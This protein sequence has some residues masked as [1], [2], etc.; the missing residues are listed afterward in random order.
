MVGNAELDPTSR[1]ARRYRAQQFADVLDLGR[2]RASLLAAQKLAVFLHR[3]AAAGGVHDY[4]IE[5]RQLGEG[6]DRGGCA[7]YGLSLCPAVKLECAAALRRRRGEYLKPLG[8]QYT[9]RGRMH[10][11]IENSL[12]APQ[13]QAHAATRLTPSCGVRGYPDATAARRGPWGQLDHRPQPLRQ[14]GGRQ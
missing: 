4:M 3:G 5:S 11:W 10:V 8:G 13:Q 7:R 14:R 2:E 12:Y 9:D 1:R 6:F